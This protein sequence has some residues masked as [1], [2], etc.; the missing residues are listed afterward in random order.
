M[1]SSFITSRPGVLHVETYSTVQMLG[2]EDTNRTKDVFTI[3]WFLCTVL[4]VK[5][6]SNV[7]FCLL[8]NQGLRIDRLLVY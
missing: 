8:S 6:D 5:S 4:P 1:I 2:F 3:N 7:M